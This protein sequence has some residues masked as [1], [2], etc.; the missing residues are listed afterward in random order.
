[1]PVS[2]LTLRRRAYLWLPAV[3]YMMAIF[4]L[5]SQPDP[6]P[7]LTTSVWDKALHTIEYAGLGV[8][9]CRALTGEGLSLRPA[10]ALAIVLVSGYGASDEWHQLYVPLRNSSVRDWMADTLGSAVG[11]AC[12]VSA[13]AVWRMGSASTASHPPRRPRR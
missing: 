3:V 7:A 8:L 1:M 10:A 11:A 13:L 9:F 12:Y 5:S 4:Y 2:P 6:L